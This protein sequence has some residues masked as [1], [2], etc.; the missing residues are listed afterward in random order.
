MTRRNY[1]D[2]TVL[3]PSQR[4]SVEAALKAVTI[5]GAIE[6]G[7]GEVTGSLVAGKSADLVVLEKS[8]FEVGVEEIKGVGVR[9][10]WL[11]GRRMVWD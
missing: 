10:T 9:E 4:V 3:G 1:Y 7:L 6:S 5:N 2:S 11:G 8:V